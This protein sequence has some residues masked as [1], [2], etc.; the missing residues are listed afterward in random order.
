MRAATSAAAAA[1]SNAASSNTTTAN[2]TSAHEARA[3]GYKL[4]CREDPVYGGSHNPSVAG[5]RFDE[6][7]YIAIPDCLWGSAEH[8]LVAPINTTGVPLF[9]LKTANASNGHY[10]EMAGGQPFCV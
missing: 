1:A 3:R 2:A 6:D 7:G 9:I 8:G 10:G 5:T 4:L